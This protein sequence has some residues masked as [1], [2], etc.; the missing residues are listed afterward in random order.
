MTTQEEKDRIEKICKQTIKKIQEEF[1]KSDVSSIV[2]GSISASMA[3][4]Y[5]GPKA[6][7]RLAHILNLFLNIE[8]DIIETETNEAHKNKEVS[9]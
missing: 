9:R 7:T 3:A 4:M 6:V 5:A 1:P 2:C 8:S